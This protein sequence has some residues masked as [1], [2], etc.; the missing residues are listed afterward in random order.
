VVDEAVVDEQP[1][2]LAE[3]MRVGL[4]DRCSGRGAD[5]GKEQRR[6][7]L[8]AQLLEVSIAPRRRNASVHAGPLAHPV[9]TDPEAVGVREVLSQARG[10]AL[11]D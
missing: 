3:R 8:R 10:P 5:M 6:H 7:D 11:L 4:L 1:A 9:P 2:P